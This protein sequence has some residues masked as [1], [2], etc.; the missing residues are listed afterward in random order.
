[1]GNIETGK[2][3]TRGSSSYNSFVSLVSTAGSIQVQSIETGSGGLFVSAF[4]LFRVTGVVNDAP[5]YSTFGNSRR[6]RNLPVSIIL[7]PFDFGN[8]N[9][10]PLRIQYGNGSTFIAQYPQTTDGQ[11]TPA[12]VQTGTSPFA[13]GP[14]V[15]GRLF[16]DIDSDIVGDTINQTYRPL[17]ADEF[18]TNVSGSVGAIAFRGS[19]AGFYGSLQNRPFIPSL[20]IDPVIPVNP[21]VD[22]GT[23]ISQPINPVLP[24]NSPS[25]PDLIA[26][27]P[28]SSSVNNPNSSS[29]KTDQLPSDPDLKAQTNA[30]NSLNI[31]TNYEQILKINLFQMP[32]QCHANGM[33]INEDGTIE[34]TGSC[35]PKDKEQLQDKMLNSP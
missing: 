26:N 7:R 14:V 25:N 27:N 11:S 35:L 29:A 2:I 33:K 12:F 24:V 9:D 15:T 18:P 1:M 10:V 16:P 30:S 17:N 5:D 22:P 4:D 19:D 32:D 13:V 8:R 20:A 23:P 6:V 21:P 34:L 28:N 3:N 31:A